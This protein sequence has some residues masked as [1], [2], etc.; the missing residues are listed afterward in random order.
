MS[1]RFVLQPRPSFDASR[2]WL[3]VVGT[4]DPEGYLAADGDHR[5]Y[6]QHC[7]EPAARDHAAYL[8]RQGRLDIRV[9][10]MRPAPCKGRRQNAHLDPG[11]S[12]KHV[13]D[14]VYADVPGEQWGGLAAMARAGVTVI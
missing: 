13:C 3:V 5:E 1:R 10:R 6:S 4:Y 7:C 8:R 2:P 12:A 11:A 9:E 14:L